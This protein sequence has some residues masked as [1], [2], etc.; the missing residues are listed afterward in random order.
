[1]SEIPKA[2]PAATPRIG[3]AGVTERH[4]PVFV[5]DAYGKKVEVIPLGGGGAGQG[6]AL[7]GG[8]PHANRVTFEVRAEF[9]GPALPGFDASRR[10]RVTRI[11]TWNTRDQEL[12]IAVARRAVELL[13]EGHPKDEN[14][15]GVF[16]I[17]LPAISIELGGHP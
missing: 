7:T 10:Q 9:E 13:Q 17:Y 11:E 6:R 12:A 1:M 5:H 2:D 8:D 15:V 4:K 16:D 3:L 14:A